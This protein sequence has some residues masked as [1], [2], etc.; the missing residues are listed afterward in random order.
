MEVLVCRSCGYVINGGERPEKC[1][2]CGMGITSFEKSDGQ[3]E[4]GLFL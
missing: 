2:V 4:D 3:D 1:P